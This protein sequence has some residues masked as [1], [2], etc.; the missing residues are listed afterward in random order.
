MVREGSAVVD[1]DIWHIVVA[2]SVIAAVGLTAAALRKQSTAARIGFS[3]LAA[4]FAAGLTTMARPVVEKA[5]FFVDD[6]F[7][8]SV[9]RGRLASN[10]P[11]GELVTLNP[12]IEKEFK[13]ALLP[14]MR[15]YDPDEPAMFDASAAATAGIIAKHVL[16]VAVS[17]STD[18]VNAWGL[19]T[20]RVVRALAAISADVCADFAMSGIIK[21]AMAP[22]VQVALQDA[23]RALIE[24]YKTSDRSRYPTP[25]QAIVAAQ[26]AKVAALAQPPFSDD[27]VRALQAIDKQPKAR[28]CNLT[29]RLFD[30]IDRLDAKDKAIIFRGMMSQA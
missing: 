4:F 10:Y 8:W 25:S 30:A 3:I 26:Y 6:D 18:A 27:E 9:V 29:L 14:V 13:A 22:R 15:K 2:V 5:L 20:T 24:A 16:P 1:T 19:Q 12:T 17:G 7:A 11:L 21:S 23:Q 28:Q